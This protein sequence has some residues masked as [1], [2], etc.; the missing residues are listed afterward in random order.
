[1]TLSPLDAGRDVGGLAIAAAEP[2]ARFVLRADEAARRAVAAAFKVDLPEKINSAA[3]QAGRAALKLGPDEWLLL[4]PQADGP[5]VAGS[6]AGALAQG[7]AS[8]VDVSHRQ[9]GLVVSGQ[10]A[11][12]LL[13]G[14]MPLDLDETAFPVGMATRTVLDKAEIVLWRVGARRFHLEVGR[15]FAPYVTA[16]LDEIRAE[17]V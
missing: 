15:S 10:R 2:F 7:A 13:N 4:A 5:I 14:A 3:A 16:L 1:M 17:N 9:I 8:L 6:L 11:T 12:S